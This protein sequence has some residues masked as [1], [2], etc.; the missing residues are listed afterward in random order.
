M[1]PRGDPVDAEAALELRSSVGLVPVLHAVQRDRSHTFS[2]G[3]RLLPRRPGS[4]L[5]G[6]Q[7][8]IDGAGLLQDEE[9]SAHDRQGDNGKANHDQDLGSGHARTL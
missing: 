2:Q 7:T 1:E 4:P 5:S 6:C 9:A 8:P 3:Q